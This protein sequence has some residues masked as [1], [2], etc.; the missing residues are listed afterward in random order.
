MFECVAISRDHISMSMSLRQHFLCYVN[1][2]TMTNHIANKIYL[3]TKH[4]NEVFL[5]IL[6]MEGSYEP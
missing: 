4:A 3:P 6:P 5:E 1:N 2:R